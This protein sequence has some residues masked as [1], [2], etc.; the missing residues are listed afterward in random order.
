[1]DDTEIEMIESRVR[2]R[3]TS[4][5][6]LW[7]IL[8]F[9]VIA[10]I[11]ASLTELDKSVRG[12][13]RVIPSSQLQ[14]VSNLEGGIVDEIFVKTGQ[15][16]PA[17]AAL[18]RLDQTLSG[19]EFSSSN[20]TIASLFAKVE[21]LK[22]EVTGH[23][24]SFP[25]IADSNVSSQVDIERALYRAQM[26]ELASISDAASARISQ[27]ERS[28]VEARAML[29][30]R[31]AAASSARSQAAMIRPLVER[32]I[33]PQMSLVQ[34]E[35]AAATSAGE[36]AAAAAALSR[37][38]ASISEAIAARGQ[39]I[40]DWRS[41]A[42][43]ELAASQAELN[44]RRSAIPALADRMKRTLVTAPIAG[45]INR[46]LVATRGGSVSPGSPLVEIVPSGES[47]IIETL[48]NPKDIAAI[49]L[50]QNAK[51]N[52][53]AYDSSVYGALTGNVIAISPDAINNERTGESHYM[54]RVRTTTNA[55]AGQGGAKLPIGPGMI[56]DVSLLGDKQSVLSYIFSPI[57]K[58][59]DTAFRE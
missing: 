16:V 47:L 19:S 10:L 17:G 34:V 44:A 25:L 13:G 41:R 51:V 4:S 22:A 14:V 35:T 45:K 33:E 5:L 32:G 48:V 59:K 36:A 9:F 29:S 2:P 20:A 7:L 8:G 3:L 12:M 21:R 54:V 27:A 30:A 49:R 15:Q 57:T 26:A 31:Q 6:M 18:V 38:Q 24:P 52:I 46:V 28:V 39:Q 50:G 58:L 23:A 53:T 55:L 11:W 1:M 43:T 56:A 40:Q 37:A 42:G